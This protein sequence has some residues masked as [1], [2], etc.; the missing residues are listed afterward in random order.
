MPVDLNK[1]TRDL[2]GIAGAVAANPTIFKRIK[3]SSQLQGFRSMAQSKGAFA[4]GVATAVT[5]VGSIAIGQIPLPGVPLLVG[6]A[7]DLLTAKL[8]ETQRKSRLNQATRVAPNVADQV[9]FELK[10]IGEMVAD[11][12]RYRWKIDHAVKKHN[13][14]AKEFSVVAARAPC[15]AWVRIWA[16]K[17][18]LN[19]RV[20]KLGESIDALRSLCDATDEWME[21]VVKDVNDA[22]DSLT[23]QYRSEV[24]MLKKMQVHDTCSEERCMFKK[25]EHT[26]QISVPTSGTANFMIKVASATTKAVM[27]DPIGD[28]VDLATAS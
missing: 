13:D 9:K 2:A 1:P 25:G 28:A 3:R 8:K 17:Y 14:A 10:S 23:I 18:Y 20:D 19:S 12:D 5:K 26:A 27:T 11:L 15:D 7:W 24:A 16:K 4:S 6:K 21:K 22:H